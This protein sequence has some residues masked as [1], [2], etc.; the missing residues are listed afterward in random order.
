MCFAV[1]TRG[2]RIINKP[3]KQCQVNI[4]YYVFALTLKVALSTTDR[5]LSAQFT[6]RTEMITYESVFGH[7]KYVIIDICIDRLTLS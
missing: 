2:Q 6:P 4:K 5:S 1:A 7:Y 3:L